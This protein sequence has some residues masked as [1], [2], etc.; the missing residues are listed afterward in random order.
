MSE[1]PLLAVSE[2]H[3]TFVQYERGLRRRLLPVVTGMDLVVDSG[4]V[5]ALVGGS[6]AGKTLL[7]HAV[8]GIL[9]PNAREEGTVAV[10]GRP[11]EPLE[12]VALAGRQLALLPQAVSFLDPMSDVG[13]QIG[14]A[15]DL[16]RGFRSNGTGDPRPRL[17]RARRRRGD[18]RAEVEARLR[19]R[20]LPPELAS[21]RPHELSGGQA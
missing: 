16:T 6:G 9:P 21:E 4:E 12:R 19:T 18:H 14:R 13:D 3:I 1:V 2:L 10:D 7:A 5:V 8:L 11:I 15:A 20:G 17:W